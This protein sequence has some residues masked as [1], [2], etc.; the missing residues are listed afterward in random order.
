M[1]AFVF[2]MDDT[3]YK[4]HNYRDS[5]YR[6]VSRHFAAS[7]DMTP[8]ALYAMMVAAPERAFETVAEMAA[9]HGVVV[10][11]DE[12]LNVYRSHR[13]DIVLDPVAEHVLR[14]LREQGMP[15]GLITDGRAWGQ[16][17]KIAALG[18]NRFFDADVIMPT[19][20]HN[21]DKH[22]PEPFEHIGALLR[23]RGATELMYVGDNPSKDFRYPNL[24]GWYTVMLRDIKNENIHSQNLAEWPA[25][26]RPRLVVD[27]LDVLLQLPG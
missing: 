15:T 7:C 10:T 19:V 22:N 4:E 3:L 23:H 24:M 5:G 1:K 21:T 26:N 14:S 27:T 11:V 12:Q 13:P 16:L 6:T 25:E 20:L 18:L 17:N 2:D 8:E 9:N